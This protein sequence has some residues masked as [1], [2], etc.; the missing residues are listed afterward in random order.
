MLP[1]DK[2]PQPIIEYF[3]HRN[4]VRSQRI[5]LIVLAAIV[6]VIVLLP[7]INV[8]ISIQGT[9]IIRPVSEKTEVKSLVSDIVEQVFVQENKVV[10][11]DAVILQLRTSSIDSKLRLLEYQKAKTSGYITDLLTLT[12]QQSVT[13]FHS[14]DYQ[15]EFTYFIKQDEE[16][17]NKCEKAKKEYERNKKLY[18]QELIS[19]KDLDNFRFQFTSGENDR[20]INHGNQLNKWQAD[21]SRNQELLNETDANILQLLKEKES[22]TI[23]SPITGTIE[24]FSGIFSGSNI[25]AGQTIAIISPD[26]TILSEVYISPKDIGYIK[27]GNPVKIQVD[28]FNYNEWGVINGVVKEVSSD[29][30]LVNNTAMFKAK[31][32]LNANFLALK[33]GIK[34]TLKKGMT[35]RAH[36]LVADRSL[37]QLLYQNLDDWINPTQ[38]RN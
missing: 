7:I 30:V 28:A 31:C 5:Y 20:K 6:I 9:G 25:N 12:A 11:K 26:S 36:F 1:I 19:E 34:G 4:T 10:Q 2:S 18:D 23:K 22:Y 38:Y 16:L 21:L 13:K 8:T 37:F 15:Q 33:N 3:M 32:N 24:Q 27:P 35:I 14:P 29:F 17:K